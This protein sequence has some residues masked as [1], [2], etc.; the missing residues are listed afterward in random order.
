MG[1]TTEK[2]S[3]PVKMLSFKEKLIDLCGESPSLKV[4]KR[5]IF[6]RSDFPD[7]YTTGGRLWG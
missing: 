2:P 1:Q 3:N 6:D 7:F 5:E 4:P